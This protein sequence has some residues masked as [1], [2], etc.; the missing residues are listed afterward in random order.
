MN[1]PSPYDLLRIV[2]KYIIAKSLTGNGTRVT[3]PVSR[4]LGNLQEA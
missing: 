2:S 3:W 1:G 4:P